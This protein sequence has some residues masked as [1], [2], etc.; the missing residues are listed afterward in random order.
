[1]SENATLGHAIFTDLEKNEYLNE[2]Y[3]SV[4]YNY[5]IKLFELD[6]N[7]AEAF[8]LDD[9]LRF[10]DILSKSYGVPNSEMHHLW[11]QEIIALLNELYPD[12]ETVRYYARCFQLS[13]IFVALHYE[14]KATAATTF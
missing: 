2:I 10:A 12:D 5:A 11:A 6:G 1:M 8:N 13:A 3:N 14:Q 7:E 9:A 4:L